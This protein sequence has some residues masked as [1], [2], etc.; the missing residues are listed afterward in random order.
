MSKY[1]S[2]HPPNIN[3]SKYYKSISHQIT[4]Q[5][6]F[7]QKKKLHRTLSEPLCHKISRVFFIPAWLKL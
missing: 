2:H 7:L 5:L 1:I 6:V 3:G 4:N